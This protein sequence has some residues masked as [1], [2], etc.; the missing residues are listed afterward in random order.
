M[1]EGGEA[2]RTGLASSRSSL[3]LYP[4]PFSRLSFL[5]LFIYVA[6]CPL[7]ISFFLLS[8]LRSCGAVLP[9]FSFMSLLSGLSVVSCRC[10]VVGGK[11]S[12]RS[13]KQSGI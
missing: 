10:V 2:G 3:S 1:K 4:F 9:L 11:V 8:I 7:F 5:F 13:G 6:R 12:N